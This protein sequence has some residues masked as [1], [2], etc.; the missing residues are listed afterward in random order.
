MVVKDILSIQWQT[1]S[2]T[3]RQRFLI[4]NDGLCLNNEYFW[5]VRSPSTLY[6]TKERNLIFVNR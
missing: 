6:F 5:L 4:A 1:S 2:V 3:K